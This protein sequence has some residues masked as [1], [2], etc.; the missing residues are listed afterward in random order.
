[1]K[2]PVIVNEIDDD[3][4]YLNKEELATLVRWIDALDR[5]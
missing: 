3:A 1:M 2:Y 5:I 4:R